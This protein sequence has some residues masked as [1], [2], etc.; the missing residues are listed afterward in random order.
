MLKRKIAVIGAGQAGLLCAIGLVDKGYEVSLFSDRT[1]ANWLNDAVPT[2]L[3]GI[4]QASIDIEHSYGLDYWGSEPVIEGV[5]LTLVPG[6]EPGPRLIGRATGPLQAVDLRLKCSRW[7]EEFETR[8]GNLVIQNIGLDELETIA[9]SHDLTVIAAGKAKLMGDIFE[10][11]AA[12]SVYTEP[13]RRLCMLIVDGVKPERFPGMKF[14]ALKFHMF[15]A[16]GEYFWLP[17]FHKTGRRCHSILFEAKPGSAMDRFNDCTSGAEGVEIAKGFIREFAPW[18]YD[19]A[20]D[21]QLMDEMAWL[22]GAFPP[23]V[24]HSVGKLPSGAIVTPIGDTAMAFDPIGGQGGNNGI[25]SAQ[26]LIEQVVAQGDAPFDEQWMIDTFE[27]HWQRFG[28]ASYAFNN[29]LLE[30]LEPAAASVIMAGVENPSIADD[31]VGRFNQPSRFFP[32]IRDP[33]LAQQHIETFA[34]ESLTP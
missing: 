7:I 5:D 32:W 33:E 14:S 23:T 28:E 10:R 18:E 30:P 11:D 21:M 8:G 12:R 1:A 19:G 25:Q 2:G 31:F 3:N 17:F 27:R 34:S 13:Q 20:K 15:P 16:L 26:N 4:Q 24:R 6:G 22:K 9:A 29:L